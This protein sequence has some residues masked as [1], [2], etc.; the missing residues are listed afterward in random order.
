MSLL[1][2]RLSCF[3]VQ[4]AEDCDVLMEEEGVD[5]FTMIHESLYAYSNSVSITDMC[6]LSIGLCQCIIFV[7][8]AIVFYNIE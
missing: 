8:F 4:P 6:L 2:I 3:G 1:C 7:Y 5:T